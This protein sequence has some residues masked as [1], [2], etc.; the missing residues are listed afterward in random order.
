[1]NSPKINN[2]FSTIYFDDYNTLFANSDAMWRAKRNQIRFDEFC[3]VTSEGYLQEL[4]G[5]QDSW[6]KENKNSFEGKTCFIFGNGPSLNDF[7]F[8]KICGYTTFGT[9]G[10]FLIHNPDFYVTV[11]TEFYK[12]YIN[13]I[14]KISCTRKF[15]TEKIQNDFPNFEG[16]VLKS[17]KNVYGFHMD[18]FFPVPF[19]FS[20][21]A[22]RIVY[23]G[24]T[25]LF[26]CLQ[27]AYFLG[28][29]KVLLAGVD[30]YFGFDRSNAFNGGI[31]IKNENY[32]KIHF[33]KHYNP[34][35]HVCHCDMIGTERAF[36]LALDSY[37]FD[38]REI[39]NVGINSKLDIFPKANLSEFID[40]K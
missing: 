35:G 18:N 17:C 28:F 20:K 12:N 5:E 11:S 36:N 7:P 29:Q 15:I 40:L 32:D 31:N 39:W 24:G 4:H 10:I 1:M 30:H 38:K 22:D 37:L 6:L 33:S 14:N 13:E 25:V 2:E 3:K 21:N 27:I 19:R 34:P 8:N 26:V 23:L 9:N 16:T